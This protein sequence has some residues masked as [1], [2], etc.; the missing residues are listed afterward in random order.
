MAKHFPWQMPPC[1]KNHP[2]P[3][4]LLNQDCQS[5]PPHHCKDNALALVTSAMKDVSKAQQR[6]AYNQDLPPIQIK[7]FFGAPYEFPLF[8]QRFQHAVMSRE[9][10]DDEN[11][12][13]RLLQFLGSEAKEAV[14]GL[15]TAVGGI[16]QA[17]KILEERIWPSVHDCQF[18]SKQPHQRA[19]HRR[20][21]Q[22]CPKEIC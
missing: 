5:H 18:C 10:I 4:R 3:F 2:S 14:C 1:F 20:G 12:M 22:S 6:L 21:G 17:I 7:K 8:K 13:T 9:D 11:K 16:Y 15:E 19:P